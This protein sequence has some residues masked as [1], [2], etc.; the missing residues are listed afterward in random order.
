MPRRYELKQR[1]ERQ[2]ET[3]RRI[4]EA[5]MALH[6]QVGP[7]RT[8]V[9]AVAERAGVQR[10]TVY[11]HFPSDE[12]L[13]GA[14][15]TAWDARN[16]P[17]SPEPALALADPE[18]RLRVLLRDLYAY[19]RR[20]EPDL[21]VFLRDAELIPALG[22]VFEEEAAGRRQLRDALARG[23]GAR[24]ARRRRLLGAI[25]LALEFDGWRSLA[26]A[27]GLDDAEAAEVMVGAARA[28]AGKSHAAGDVG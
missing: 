16:P 15:T 6:A 21:R 3:R 25:G 23:W 13:L 10:H 14:C 2:Q 18:E 20:V 11:R 5:A 4:V 17:P 22:R 19:Y 12:E 8:T 24:G 27:Q 1:A 9:K 26:R 7:A 28:A